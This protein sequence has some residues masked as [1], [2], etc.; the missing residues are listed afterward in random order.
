MEFYIVDVFAKKPYEGNQLAV[1][2]PDEDI[3]QEEMQQIAK[4]INFSETTFIMSGLQKNN[5]YNVK[6]FTPDSEIPFAGHPTLGTAYVIQR[7][8]DGNNSNEIKL[9]LEV[10]QIPV[11]FN[12]QE[13]LGCYKTNQYLKIQ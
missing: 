12:G 1:C 3:K 4:E 10:G 9:N 7:F 6:I 8:I 11:M 13:G 2:I 5:G